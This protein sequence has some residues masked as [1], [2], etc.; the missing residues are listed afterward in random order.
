MRYINLRLTYLLTI[1]ASFGMKLTSLK[2]KFK[3]RLNRNVEVTRWCRSC[4]YTGGALSRS[5]SALC[6][7][8]TTSCRQWHVD[9]DD[10]G[11]VRAGWWEYLLP[12]HVIPHTRGAAF[13]GAEEAM[14]RVSDEKKWPTFLRLKNRPRVYFNVPLSSRTHC[15]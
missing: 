1:K 3:F 10:D 8:L 7:V 14:D 9:K 5:L 11:D 12:S 13:V 4:V 2:F 6:A 15:L